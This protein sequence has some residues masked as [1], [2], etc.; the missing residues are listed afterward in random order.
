VLAEATGENS[1]LSN[2]ERKELLSF[3]V[4]EVANRLP[5]LTTVDANNTQLAVEYVTETESLGI[6]GFLIVTPFYNRPTQAGLYRHFEALSKATKLPICLYS[7]QFRCGTELSTETVRQLRKNYKN[8]IGIQEGGG[9]CNRVSQLVKENDE[10][11][12]VLAGDDALALPFFA[13]G[14]KGLVSV[15]ANLIP[16]EIVRLYHLIASNDFEHAA[17]INRQYYPLFRA[18]TI[19]P[20]PVP[21]KYLLQRNGLIASAEVRLPLC[22]LSETNAAALDRL[23]ET[24]KTVN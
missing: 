19:E 16:E 14:A 3:T 13:L 7:S 4:N 20:D 18:L 2:E 23:I 9:S 12:Y 1:T 6:D 17:D 5:I 11:F 15:A 24:L 21:I 8:I 10:D 22:A